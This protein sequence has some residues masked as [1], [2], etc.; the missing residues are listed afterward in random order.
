MLVPVLLEETEYL[1]FAFGFAMNRTCPNIVFFSEK[2][3][4]LVT[5]IFSSDWENLDHEDGICDL[6]MLCGIEDFSS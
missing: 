5:C 3:L 6:T 2:F 4:N 1:Y